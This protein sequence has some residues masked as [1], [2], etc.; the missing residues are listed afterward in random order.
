MLILSF[1][2]NSLL[3]CY[4]FLTRPLAHK[5][6][7]PPPSAS[8]DEAASEM[9]LIQMAPFLQSF[10]SALRVQLCP[11]FFFFLNKHSSLFLLCLLLSSWLHSIWDLGSPARD[12]TCAPLRWKCGAGCWTTREVP[13]L[14]SCTEIVSMMYSSS[15]AGLSP[16]H[17]WS[18]GRNR[19]FS[20]TP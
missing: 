12:R 4:W 19:V 20:F 8:I 11:A 15:A 2:L 3:W 9:E 17:A 13:A 7:Q 5:Q 10:P 14:Y 1:H 16:S 6:V 18:V